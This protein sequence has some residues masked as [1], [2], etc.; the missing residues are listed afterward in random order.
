MQCRKKVNSLLF[1][2][3]SSLWAYGNNLWLI[4]FSLSWKPV[5][6]V[7]WYIFHRAA[8]HFLLKIRKT[9]IKQMQQLKTLL[10][11][12]ESDK[13]LSL[14]LSNQLVIPHLLKVSH[15]CAA[16]ISIKVLSKSSFRIPYFMNYCRKKIHF[17]INVISYNEMYHAYCSH[18]KLQIK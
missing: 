8:K 7:A 4:K 10:F 16:L 14:S 9:P 18:Y 1:L 11:G 12:F 5:S 13:T 6:P 3:L 2:S 15:S 17:L